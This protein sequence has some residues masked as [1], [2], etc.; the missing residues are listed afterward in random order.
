MFRSDQTQGATQNNVDKV[1]K[2]T[3]T[4]D[5]LD[6]ELCG[7]FCRL[8]YCFVVVCHIGDDDLYS[9]FGKEDVAPALATHDLEYDPAFQVT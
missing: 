8:C 9:G 7:C 5:F 1:W 2:K 4:E 6:F 3:H